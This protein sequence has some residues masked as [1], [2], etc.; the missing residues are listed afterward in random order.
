MISEQ[1]VARVAHLARIS[2]STEETQALAQQLSSVLK[3]FE[4]VAKVKTDGIEP[5]VTATD[6]E[7]FWRPDQAVAWENAEAA[8]ANAPEAIGNLFKV[9]PVVG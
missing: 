5:L 6:M 3:H 4:Q 8:M 7:T 9:P 1:D 2:L